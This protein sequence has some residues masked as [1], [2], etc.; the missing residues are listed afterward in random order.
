M[1]HKFSTD[2]RVHYDKAVGKW[3]YEDETNGQEFEWNEPGQT[4]VPVVSV[5]G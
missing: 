5:E 1:P 4:W 2:P 3:Q